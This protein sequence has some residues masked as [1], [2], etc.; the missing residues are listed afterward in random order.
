MPPIASPPSNTPNRWGYARLKLSYADT[1]V[2]SEQ[3]IILIDCRDLLW[4]SGIEPVH[5][6]TPFWIG[7]PVIIEDTLL[8]FSSPYSTNNSM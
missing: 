4:F 5:Q 6:V 7:E 8:L 3:E 1:G 2:L